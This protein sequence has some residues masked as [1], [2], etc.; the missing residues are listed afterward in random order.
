[1]R[2]RL[3][4]TALVCGGLALS[5]TAQAATASLDGKKV[6]KLTATFSPGAQDND[7]DFVLDSVKPKDRVACDTSRCGTLPFVYKPAKGVKGDLVFTITWTV[8]GQDFDLYVVEY[9]K[10]GSRSQL[11][12]CGSFAGTSEKVVVPSTDLKPGKKY[13]LLVDYYRT[14]GT[15]KV[16]GTVEFPAS[17]TLKSLPT[18]SAGLAT[19]C[20]LS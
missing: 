11:A 15:D 14:A 7:P 13:G 16:T 9:A 10:D 19:G 1:M 20:G 2:T 12:T 18:D 8:P 4:A 3:L 5:Q 17:A 6:K